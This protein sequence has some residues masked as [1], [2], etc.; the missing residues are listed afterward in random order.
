RQ[1]AEHH[2]GH[3]LQLRLHGR[4]NVRMPVS[5]TS[6]PPACYPINQFPPIRQFQ[7]HPVRRH[8]RQRQ[9]R[10]FHLR[11]REPHMIQVE[12]GRSLSHGLYSP[13]AQDELRCNGCKTTGGCNLRLS[14]ARKKLMRP[15]SISVPAQRAARSGDTGGTNLYT[16]SRV[17]SVPIPASR[18]TDTRSDPS[19][20]PVWMGFQYTASSAAH[21]NADKVVFPT[22]VSVPV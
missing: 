14:N 4:Q 2:V 18:I 8:N 7:S 17:R 22:P 12:P 13:S 11:I 20:V 16:S 5:M 6:R 21:N 10:P 1:P 15:R 9:P 19:S 3:L